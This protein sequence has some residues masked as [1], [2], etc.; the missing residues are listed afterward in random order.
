MLGFFNHKLR[1]LLLVMSALHPS[2]YELNESH[3]PDRICEII[4]VFLMTWLMTNYLCHLNF[5]QAI[6]LGFLFCLFSGGVQ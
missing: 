4:D 3:L 1:V 6:L 2:I 5:E